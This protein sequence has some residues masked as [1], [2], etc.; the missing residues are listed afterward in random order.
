MTVC[1]PPLH[2]R[3]NRVNKL[4]ETVEANRLFGAQRFIFY[5]Y[6]AGRD[7]T[8][9]LRGYE[10]EG[11]ATV[12]PWPL[13]LRVNVWPPEVEFLFHQCMGTLTVDETDKHFNG[14][15]QLINKV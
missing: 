4:V 15:H 6:T 12:V 13:P 14:K 9:V 10:A 5:N 1:V 3:Y 8:R 11:L 7:V 2:F